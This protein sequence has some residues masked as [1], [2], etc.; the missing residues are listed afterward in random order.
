MERNSTRAVMNIRE[1]AEKKMQISAVQWITLAS[2]SCPTETIATITNAVT[3]DVST[4]M[5]GTSS[6]GKINSVT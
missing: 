5:T 1:D 2:G 6:S 3:S 4:A